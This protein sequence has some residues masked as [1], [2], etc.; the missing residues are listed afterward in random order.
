MSYRR[1]VR[2]GLSNFERVFRG[3]LLYFRFSLTW[4]RV[5]LQSGSSCHVRWA[6]RSDTCTCRA[7]RRTNSDRARRKVSGGPMAYPLAHCQ[8][9]SRSQSDT[10]VSTLLLQIIVGTLVR[11]RRCWVVFWP[12]LAGS[13]SWFE[14]VCFM[15]GFLAQL[16][17]SESWF[18][19]V[20][21]GVVF[22]LAFATKWP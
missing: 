10:F 1:C 11:N 12:S 9:E 3:G 16:A 22:W 8:L 18:E 5:P 14:I 15:G 20:G 19:I 2:A 21:F 13:E 7:A 6:H 4:T 17:G